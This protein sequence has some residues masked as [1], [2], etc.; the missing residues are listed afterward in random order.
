MGNSVHN[1]VAS[2][3]TEMNV[4]SSRVLK[5][6]PLDPW[7][8]TRAEREGRQQAWQCAN[9]LRK[10]AAGY[11]NSY[12]LDTNMHIGLRDS[13]R[14]VG[15]A[16]ATAD[17]VLEFRKYDDGIARSS[18]DIDI[19]PAESYTAPA[20]DRESAGYQ[21]RKEKIMAGDY[22]DIRLGS[23]IASGIDNLLVA[24]RC[25]S[26]EQQAQASL[27]IQQTCQSTG[28]AAGAA[29]ALSLQNNVPPREIEPTIVVNHLAKARDIEPA[30]P[31]LAR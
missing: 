16:T 22:F 10:Y 14:I 17:D 26:A 21:A 18:W 3:R 24:G 25:L 19:W 13:R 31:E 15:C 28:Q 30:F 7:D 29:A 20:V 5:V 8:I 9:A 4:F 1:S 11:E 12:L 27:R 6:N 23:I 2:Y